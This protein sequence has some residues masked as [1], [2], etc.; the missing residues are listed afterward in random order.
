MAAVATA[1]D[2]GSGETSRRR[3]REDLPSELERMLTPLFDTLE[4]ELCGV[5][6][7]A[8]RADNFY[9]LG[10]LVRTE[11]CARRH[12][13]TP[14]ERAGGP[15]GPR[16]S[17]FL[18]HLLGAL[19]RSTVQLFNKF[20]DDQCA[21][22]RSLKD[23]SKK[24]GVLSCFRRFPLFVD[25]M[26][27]VLLRARASSAQQ[28]DDASAS[29]TVDDAGADDGDSAHVSLLK[30]VVSTAYHKLAVVMFR[31]LEQL[32]L[33]GKQRHLLRI[34]NYSHF[35]LQLALRPQ[36]TAL[37]DYVVQV[38]TKTPR[39]KKKKSDANTLQ[40][41]QRL[42]QCTDDFCDY[43]LRKEFAAFVEFFNGVDQLLDGDL[44]AE[45]VQYQSSYSKP[46]LNKLAAK[47]A[48]V[49]K[50][51][52]RIRQRISDN[53]ADAALVE[54]LWHAFKQHFVAKCRHAE[55]LCQ[56]CY[57][58]AAPLALDS[59]ETTFAKVDEQPG[60]SAGSNSKRK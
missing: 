40:A 14:A 59:L 25:H 26:Q 42:Q 52:L 20:I 24:S 32:E 8:D 53:V 37:Q 56:R 49:D 1:S 54:Q 9:P 51:V 57:K 60:G 55:E 31:W 3:T 47:L 48:N 44:P 33:D 38:T 7:L 22:V 6:E 45:E 21:A 34:E 17:A 36:A 10:I 29:I 27:G 2:E 43:L 30:G 18:L 50:G 46:V 5:V 4:S 23:P 35:A 16:G 28:L 13:L 12:A 19:Q 39:K 41:E 11:R 58:T 15:C